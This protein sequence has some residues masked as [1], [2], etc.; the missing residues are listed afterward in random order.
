M[1]VITTSAADASSIQEH[2]IIV[3]AAAQSLRLILRKQLMIMH[4]VHDPGYI[5]LVSPS[6]GALS[7]VKRLLM[8]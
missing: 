2:G 4:G 1:T 3:L 8:L 7:T 5:L 6:Y